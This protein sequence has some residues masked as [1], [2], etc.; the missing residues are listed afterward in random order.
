MWVAKS[1]RLGI[2]KP[3]SEIAT[4]IANMTNAKFA[5]PN[6]LLMNES[7]TSKKNELA[8]IPMLL[9]IWWGNVSRN[10]I[11]VEGEEQRQNV[12]HFPVSAT[13]RPVCVGSDLAGSAKRTEQ[14]QMGEPVTKS[15]RKRAQRK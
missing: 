9:P 10:P 3:F 11:S 6:Q 5:R 15:K 2:A 8:P 14:H 4:S 7:G 13:S 1:D 12:F